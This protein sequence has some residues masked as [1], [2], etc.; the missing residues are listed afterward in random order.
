MGRIGEWRDDVDAAASS[1]ARS[2]R[3]WL[4]RQAA[5][6]TTCAGVLLTLGERDAPVTIRTAGGGHRGTITSVTAALCTLDTGRARVLIPLTAITA[7]TAMAAVDGGPAEI[8]DDR[9]PRATADLAAVLAELA[10]ERPPVIVQLSDST[11]ASP[12]L[13]RSWAPTWSAWPPAASPMCR[14]ARSRAAS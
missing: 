5:E 9:S 6:A 12:A 11:T 10:P 4:R 3:Y 2:R 8:S 14:W 7:V 13:W 1:Q